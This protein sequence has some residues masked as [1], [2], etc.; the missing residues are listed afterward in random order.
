MFTY[1][2]TGQVDYFKIHIKYKLRESYNVEYSKE[3]ED[4][5]PRRVGGGEVFYPA[6]L[7]RG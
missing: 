5:H 1:W 2:F 7:H 3:G 4:P 6:S